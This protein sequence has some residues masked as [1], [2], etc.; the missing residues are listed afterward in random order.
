MIG[1]VLVFG[2]LILLIRSWLALV[3]I[4]GSSAAPSLRS[5]WGVAGMWTVPLVFAPPLF[6][7]DMYSYAA[8]GEMVSHHITPYLYGPNVL[9]AGVNYQRLV[10]PV[11]GNTPAPY[12]PL[13]LKLD[14]LAASVTGHN[15]LATLMLL[16]LL[17]VL[18]MAL[19]GFGV[20]SLGR[21]LGWGPLLPFVL[22]ACNP[23]LLMHFV[24]GGHNDALM[25]GLLAAG[26][27]AAARKPH[28]AI[29]AC[30]L[31]A[32]VK[33]P[34]AIGI[35]FVGWNWAG[36]GARFGQRLRRLM[37]AGAESL[38]VMEIVATAT[39]L[40][41]GWVRDMG[42]E[43]AIVA[44]TTPT[45]LLA[46]V[47]TWISRLLGLHASLHTFLPAVRIAGMLAAG[48][49]TMWLLRHAERFGW[50]TAAGMSLLIFSLLAP[51]VEPW[52]LAWGLGLLAAAPTSRVRKL[53]VAV[54]VAGTFLNLPAGRSIPH[55]VLAQSLPG[56]LLFMAAAMFVFLVPV[57][58]R[59]ERQASLSPSLDRLETLR[60]A[61]GEPAPALD[62][63]LAGA[64]LA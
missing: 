29:V 3:G 51:V 35:L 62:E 41:W 47:S 23:L 55:L 64:S 2:G 57:L 22:V 24:A 61:D 7:R 63:A 46:D 16:R 15:E 19:L 56:R 14:G 1:I 58:R 20:A 6:S 38:L 40:G 54:S 59:R 45:T 21:R 48:L 27:A 60:Q 25:L 43:S 53:V 10:D 30:T 39:G 31:A 50:V 52:Y 5:L 4:A 11:W 36:P 32:A 37:L 28:L 34:A 17:A 33:A 49:A 42:S 8:Q 18:G 12:G 9:G 13:F 44:W 26:M